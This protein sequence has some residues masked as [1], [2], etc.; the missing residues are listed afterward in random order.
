MRSTGITSARLGPLG[1]SIGLITQAVFPS[2]IGTEVVPARPAS[3]SAVVASLVPAGSSV[4]GGNWEPDDKGTPVLVPIR[5]VSSLVFTM[6]S[7]DMGRSLSTAFSRSLCSTPLPE[8]VTTTG[9][10]GVSMM[11]PGGES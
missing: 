6:P 8:S 7:T 11:V 9:P 1:I 2:P 4:P 10:S 3:I 5:K